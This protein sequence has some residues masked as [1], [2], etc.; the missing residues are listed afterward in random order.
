M[1]GG[2]WGGSRG[3]Q[4]SWLPRCSLTSQRAVLGAPGARG[5]SGEGAGRAFSGADSAPGLHGLDQG[6]DAAGQGHGHLAWWP[7]H[8]PP[9]A[10]LVEGA[11]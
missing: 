11:P 6:T 7:R 9:T 3:H 8:L 1:A 2:C 10:S 4:P 5:Q